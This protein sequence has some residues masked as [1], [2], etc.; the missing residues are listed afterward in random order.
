MPSPRRFD[1]VP[2][3]WPR[4]MRLEVAAAYLGLSQTTLL[5]ESKAGR[6]PAPA[7]VTAGRRIWDK[8]DLDAHLD[9][10][11]GRGDPTAPAVWLDRCRN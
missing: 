2:Q 8:K 3:A 10:L 6:L 7:F 1:L 11:F 4:G 9:R 5:T